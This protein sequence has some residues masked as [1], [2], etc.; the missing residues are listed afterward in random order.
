MLRI[1]RS[2]SGEAD[3]TLSARRDAENIAELPNPGLPPK[4]YLC[5]Q[6]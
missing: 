3:F 4:E 6:L 1:Q 5:D 2:E